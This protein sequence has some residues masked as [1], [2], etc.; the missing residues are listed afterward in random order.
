MREHLYKLIREG[1]R[2]APLLLGLLLLLF[3]LAVVLGWSAANGLMDGRQNEIW[4]VGNALDLYGAFVDRDAWHLDYFMW[5]NYWPPGFYLFPWPLFAF[6]GATHEVMVLSNLG[7]LAILLASVYLLGV[8]VRGRSVG[9][10]AMAL[11]TLY[12]GVMGNMVRYEPS[13]AVTAWVTLAALALARSRGFMMRGA[14]VMFALAVAGGLMMDRLSLALFIALPALY[15][16]MRGLGQG[17]KRRRSVNVILGIVIVTAL[18]GYWHWEFVHRH[19]EE[20]VSQ[21]AGEIDATGAYTE[22][23]DPTSLKSI[24]FVFAVL[25]DGQ[26]GLLP[27]LLGIAAIGWW[28][29]SR[30]SRA[31]V[32]GLVVLS[33]LLLFSLIQKKQVYYTVPI[34]GCLAVL[35]ADLVSRLPAPR[36]VGAG[37]VALLAAQL[38]HRMSDNPP[39]GHGALQESLLGHGLTEGFGDGR[40][41]QT[42]PPLGL[43]LPLDEVAAALP[44]GDVITFSEDS[45][46]FEGYVTLQMREALPESQVRGVI[47]DPWG[48]FEWYRAVGS[49]VIVQSSPEVRWPS[50]ATLERGL[51]DHNY[52]LEDLPPVA[53]LIAGGGE[54]GRFELLGS[55]PW[56]DGVVSAWGN[57]S[58]L[59]R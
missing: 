50:Q 36:V 45:L 46:W 53:E 48:S 8:E 22:L 40:Y 1:S 13:V 11:V 57:S 18:V 21:G 14:S 26:A 25:L 9:L 33:S 4:H 16:F 15:E 52:A 39:L 56:R 54:D 55:W 47:G 27:G 12:P 49:F 51:T 19:L 28:L 31:R 38:G 24:L 32:A 2:R 29:A 35:T 41:P 7:H 20:I 30:H 3:S 6:L 34:L 59:P 17:A 44:P 58:V 37:L 42:S 5:T 43:D 23:R 10:L